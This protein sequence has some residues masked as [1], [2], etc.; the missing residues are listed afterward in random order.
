MNRL[1]GLLFIGLLLAGAPLH[2]ALDIRITKGISDATPIAIAPFSFQGKG[3]APGAVG[4]IVMADLKRSGRFSPLDRDRFAQPDVNASNLQLYRWRESN[5]NY[6]VVGSILEQAKGTYKIQFQLFDS[7]SAKQL[8]GYSIPTDSNNIRMA[9]HQVSDLIYEAIIGTRGAFNTRI[10]YIT[11]QGQGDDKRYILQV[12]DSDGHNARTILN[13]HS[14]LMSPVWSPDAKQLAYV[15][16]ENNR[17]N[18]YIQDVMTGKRERISSRTGINGAPAWSRDGRK[19]ALTLSETG[20]PEI[21]VLEIKSKRLSKLTSDRAINTEPVWMPDGRSI[22][23]TSNRT[24]KPQLYK[25]S[26]SG[27]QAQRLSYEGD[28]NA[29]PAV[30]ADGKKIAMVNGEQGRFRI[31]ML[32][33]QSGE[34][35]VLTNGRLDESPSFAP[36]GSMIIYA[37]EEK[38]RGVLSAVSDDGR[39]RQTLVLQEGEVREPDWSPFIN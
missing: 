24:G 26:S 12:A 7:V 38:G 10:V 32:D 20:S 27:G 33:L 23:F 13:S 35:Q 17:S 1:K 2:A 37:T 15:S 34:T 4:D 25:V 39:V 31:A 22:V 3:D 6:V 9:A 30:S 5:I 29:A 36:N 14:P 11:T 28:F 18:I 19:L 16:F 8:S 21:Y